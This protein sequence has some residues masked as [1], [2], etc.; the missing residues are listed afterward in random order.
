[1]GKNKRKVSQRYTEITPEI[2]IENALRHLQFF[3]APSVAFI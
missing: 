2:P 3:F 1:M